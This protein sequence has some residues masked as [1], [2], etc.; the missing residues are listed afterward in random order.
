MVW[1]GGGKIFFDYTCREE[2]TAFS[3]V[4]LLVSNINQFVSDSDLVDHGNLKSAFLARFSNRSLR[5]RFIGFLT[6]TRQETTTGSRHGRKLAL[7]V[8]ITA[9]PPG[10]NDTLPRLRIFQTRE[11]RYSLSIAFLAARKI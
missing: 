2:Y 1:F 4:F 7:G 8:R 3:I 5:G 11:R 9:Y 6:T 10:A